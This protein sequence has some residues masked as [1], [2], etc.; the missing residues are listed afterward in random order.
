MYRNY[1]GVLGPF[2][3][4]RQE[5]EANAWPIDDEFRKDT[6]IQL[7]GTNP[8]YETQ[9]G[10]CNFYKYCTELASG[11]N[12]YIAGGVL[13]CT[14]RLIQKHRGLVKGNIRLY[15]ESKLSPD[16]ADENRSA[17]YCCVMIYGTSDTKTINETWVKAFVDHPPPPSSVELL[18]N[19]YEIAAR[20]LMKQYMAVQ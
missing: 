10:G 5:C 11:N 6:P 7:P 17:A 3:R 8:E 2:G 15:P 4:Y 9:R 20:E 13:M 16:L 18:E 19:A 12:L 14:P 1:R